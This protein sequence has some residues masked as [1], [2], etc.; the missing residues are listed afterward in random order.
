MNLTAL[1]LDNLKSSDALVMLMMH[2]WPETY[3]PEIIKLFGQTRALRF[4]DFFGGL[5]VDVPSREVMV[6]LVK[7]VDIYTAMEGD[8]SILSVDRLSVKYEVSPESIKRTHKKV[9]AIADKLK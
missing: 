3:M 2:E 8:D 9:R 1:N 6:K 7:D 4:I 5:T